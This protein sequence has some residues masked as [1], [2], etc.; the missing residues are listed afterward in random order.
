MPQE[1]PIPPTYLNQDI[2]EALPMLEGGTIEDILNNRKAS[3]EVYV[4]CRVR[5]NALREFSYENI[6]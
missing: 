1:C 2:D 5:L 4:I 6:D 3:V